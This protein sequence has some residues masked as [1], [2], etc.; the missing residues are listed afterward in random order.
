MCCMPGGPGGPGCMPC[1]GGGA[2]KGAGGPPPAAGICPGMPGGRMGGAPPTGCPSGGM[3]PP[4]DLIGEGPTPITCCCPGVTGPE[5]A[6]PTAPPA[7]GAP[8]ALKAG[9][10][11]APGGWLP[12]IMGGRGGPPG[13]PLKA[14]GPPGGP[15]NGGMPVVPLMGGRGRPALAGPAGCCSPPCSP[16][17]P[18]LAKGTVPG[19]CTPAPDMG[20]RAIGGTPAPAPSAAAGGAAPAPGGP[21]RLPG[22]ARGAVPAMGGLGKPPL[23]G[24]NSEGGLGKPPVAAEDGPC[25]PPEASGAWGAALRGATPLAAASGAPPSGPPTCGLA[26]GAAPANAGG[27]FPTTSPGAPAGTKPGFV[28]CCCCCAPGAPG[29]CEKAG[30]P[31]R[32]GCIVAAA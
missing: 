10:P 25:R 31:G 11:G 1:E 27:P 24:P 2:M 14:G 32:C 18:G 19:G 16:T 22:R 4:G 7:A 20:G 29:G 12:A 3:P 13:G 8:G 15:R 26:P 21:T 17:P 28:C 6:N 9:G 30:G 23:G 5:A